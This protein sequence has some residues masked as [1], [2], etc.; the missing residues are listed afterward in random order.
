MHLPLQMLLQVVLQHGPDRQQ[1]AGEIRK[2]QQT[3]CKIS[4]YTLHTKATQR[5]QCACRVARA[6]TEHM[7]TAAMKTPLQHKTNALHTT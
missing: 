3:S 5:V 6:H 1:L 4:E 2:L 7:H